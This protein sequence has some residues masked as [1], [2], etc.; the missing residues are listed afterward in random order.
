VVR[1]ADVKHLAARSHDLLLF[2]V[3]VEKNLALDEVDT[4]LWFSR[5]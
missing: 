3:E 5:R 4:G 2:F 1:S